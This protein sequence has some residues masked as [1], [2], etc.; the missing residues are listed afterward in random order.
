MLPS[1]PQSIGGVLDAGFHVFRSTLK[2]VAIPAT[3]MAVVLAGL[4]L[5]MAHSFDYE[6]LAA[7]QNPDP[8]TPPAF[9]RIGPLFWVLWALYI[10][11]FVMFFIVVASHQWALI[12]GREPSLADSI[13]RGLT[14]LVPLLVASFLYYVAI[15]LGFVLLII[16]GL[17]IMVS[18]SLYAFVPIVE[19]RSA[20]TAITRSHA[21]VWGGNWFRT[22]AV[23]TVLMAISVALTITLELVFGA[24]TGI[25]S[26]IQP[27]APN[28]WATIS[29]ALLTVALYPLFTAVMLAL[30]HDLLLRKEAGDLDSRLQALDEPSA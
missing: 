28:P 24:P 10:A 14:L 25:S 27:T 1:E 22:A 8:G 29:G 26:V 9:P 18:M 5:G 12:K 16:P 7:M 4:A 17:I 2:S 6:A 13:L 15:A 20:W 19:D 3:V 23:L 30:Y 21:L 11:S